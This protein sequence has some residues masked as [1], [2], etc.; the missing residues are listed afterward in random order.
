MAV[1]RPRNITDEELESQGPWLDHPLDVP[2]DMSYFLL[3]IRS[4]ELAR[5]CSDAWPMATNDIDSVE[6]SEIV[7]IDAKFEE[8]LRDMPVFFRLDD[9]SRRQSHPITIK[10]PHLIIQKYLLGIAIY[11]RRC[12]LHQP[13][14]V[15][16]SQDDRYRYSRETCIRAARSVIHAKQQLDEENNEIVERQLPLN[17][18]ILHHLFVATI[19]LVMD[20]CFT[21]QEESD[22]VRRQ[23]VI[24]ACKALE[25]TKTTS[26]LASKFLSSLTDVLRKHKINLGPQNELKGDFS[27]D[28]NFAMHGQS[29]K[30][31]QNHATQ[32]IQP[33]QLDDAWQ[34]WL[35]QGANFE[36]MESTN[37]DSL[38]SD[39]D[40]MES[41]ASI[42][43]N[44]L[45]D[46]S[47]LGQYMK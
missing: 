14:L 3:R 18:F 28:P 37:W 21:R 46:L 27:N 45:A 30:I 8:V 2:T 42:D 25:S 10:F 26:A 19:V 20:L 23:E 29:I 16:G 38:F 5:M 7:A 13:F 34:D 22:D 15:R 33:F 17:L 47:N 43:M 1:K 40:N 24:Y 6:Y 44:N 36:H 12:K 39:L 35:S 41:I 4:A 11:M 32:P 31:L 9:A